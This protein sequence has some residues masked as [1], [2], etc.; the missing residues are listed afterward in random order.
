[1]QDEPSLLFDFRLYDHEAVRFYILNSV[2]V[3][4]PALD[5]L[6]KDTALKPLHV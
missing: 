2:C 3:V 4:H 6:P 1:M 5:V